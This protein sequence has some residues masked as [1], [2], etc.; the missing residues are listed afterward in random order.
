MMQIA[1]FR[2]LG[3]IDKVVF[4]IPTVKRVPGGLG[5][6][7]ESRERRPAKYHAESAHEVAVIF[8]LELNRGESV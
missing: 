4:P 1:P 6:L 7:C 2:R 5:H 8:D 3:R